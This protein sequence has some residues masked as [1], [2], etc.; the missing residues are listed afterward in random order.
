MAVFVA[1]DFSEDE[2]IL[3][4]SSIDM[5]SRAT[6]DL[7]RWHVVDHQLT[8]SP[9]QHANGPLLVNVN[10][11]RG[12]PDAPWVREWDGVHAASRL[13]LLGRRSFDDSRQTLA[14]IWL[15]EDRLGD[16]NARRLIGAH[17][18][19]H[20]L[21]LNHVK[22]KRSVMSEVY[23]GK[24]TCLSRDDLVEF[25]N[26]FGCDASTMNGSLWATCGDV[27]DTVVRAHPGP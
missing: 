7:I 21:G 20:A 15:V 11:Y 8:R 16:D 9:I 22:D 10:C 1:S 23:D 3:L 4:L 2:R 25:C 17:E 14:S 18:F 19:G 13:K 24:T 12:Q 6:G 27:A 5:W 26:K